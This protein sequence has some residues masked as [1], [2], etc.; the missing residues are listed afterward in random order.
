MN[1][2][3]NSKHLPTQVHIYVAVFLL[4]FS[5]L[6]FAAHDH[7]D[8]AASSNAT[9]HICVIADHSNAI[10]HVNETPHFHQFDETILH[11]YSDGRITVSHFSH[12]CARAPPV[13]L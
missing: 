1:F 11:E 7:T 10:N 9:C 5:Q 2:S 6:V 8:E 13:C 3:F 4:L 12:T